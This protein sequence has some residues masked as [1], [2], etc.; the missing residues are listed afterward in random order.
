MD[1]ALM[2]S[3]RH[4]DRISKA[5]RNSC[6]VKHY[7]D[8]VRTASPLLLVMISKAALSRRQHYHHQLAKLPSTWLIC[9]ATIFWDS[10]C[11]L[12]EK[13]CS[14]DV[15][16]A[17][18]RTALRLPLVQEMKAARGVISK[19]LVTI[20][21][22]IKR[23]TAAVQTESSPQ[24]VLTTLVALVRSTL[25]LCPPNPFEPFL[26]FIFNLLQLRIRPLFLAPS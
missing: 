6:V 19:D 4:K 8:V 1:V 3:H 12:E 24:M 25:L 5:A 17:V 11:N 7:S 2:K 22:A 14:R 13:M 26:Y 20:F 18:V 23:S 10:L 21:R 16:L 15:D 9:R